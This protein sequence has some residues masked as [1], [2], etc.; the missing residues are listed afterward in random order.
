MCCCEFHAVTV[1]PVA[2][3]KVVI[4]FTVPIDIRDIQYVVN[5]I[6]TLVTIP[7]TPPISSNINGRKSIVTSRTRSSY[8]RNFHYKLKRSRKD[9]KTNTSDAFSQTDLHLYKNSLRHW[10]RSRRPDSRRWTKSLAT[11]AV[12]RH[13]L[14]PWYAI[15]WANDFE[16]TVRRRGTDI[17]TQR[18]TSV[19]L[20][21]Q[22]RNWCGHH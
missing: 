6:N 1:R 11:L 10:R 16:L 18:H 21:I 20:P 22:K 9:N 7:Q 15:H 2:L 5:K 4:W 8:R 12:R 17:T 14:I 3:I 13:S 19:H